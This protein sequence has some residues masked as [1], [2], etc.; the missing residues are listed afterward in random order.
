MLYFEN[1][2][3]ELVAKL[4]PA[5]HDLQALTIKAMKKP[6]SI[7]GFSANRSWSF[8]R[9]LHLEISSSSAQLQFYKTWNGDTIDSV[10]N[11]IFK[12]APNLVGLRLPI[13]NE[14]G[15]PSFEISLAGVEF[16]DQ[17]LFLELESHCPGI[18]IDLR[19]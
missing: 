10:I 11:S 8:L 3:H 16:P 17:F 2:D 15:V 19:G 4:L 6:L 9:F 5:T 13:P 1:A 18:Y 12:V 7:Y 14:P